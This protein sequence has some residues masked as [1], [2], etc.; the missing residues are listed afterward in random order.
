MFQDSSL[1]EEPFSNEAGIYVLA[2]SPFVLNIEINITVNQMND[3]ISIIC[4]KKFAH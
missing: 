2:L 1:E 4:K 3:V